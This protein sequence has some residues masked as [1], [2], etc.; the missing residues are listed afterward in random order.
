MELPQQINQFILRGQFA[1]CNMISTP[2]ACVRLP[3]KILMINP[4]VLAQ[5]SFLLLDKTAVAEHRA[6][7]RQVL[8]ISDFHKLFPVMSPDEGYHTV[9][10]TVLEALH[11][12]EVQR[13]AIG[14]LDGVEQSLFSWEL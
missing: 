9:E 14:I 5:E 4:Y 2:I 12:H 1:V 10:L 3:I 7:R 6:R 13:R 11:V 8:G